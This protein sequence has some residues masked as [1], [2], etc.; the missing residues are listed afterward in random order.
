MQAQHQL[1]SSRIAAANHYDEVAEAIGTA[2]ASWPPPATVV[3]TLLEPDGAHRFVGAYGMSAYDRSEWARV[4]PQFDVPIVTVARDRTVLV[5]TDRAELRARFPTMVTDRYGAEAVF[6]APLLD[7]DRVIGSLGLTWKESLTVDDDIRRYLGALA[8]PAARKVAE[9]TGDEAAAGAAWVL[10]TGLETEGWLPIVLETIADPAMVLAPV[11][12][13]DRV[14]DFAVEYANTAA[15]ELLKVTRVGSDQTLLETYPRIGAELLLPGFT[16]LL[17][18]GGP[19]NVGPARLNAAADPADPDAAQVMTV[20]ASRVWDRV[21]MTWRIHSEAE[22]IY[23]QL[24]EAERIGRIGSFSWE[25]GS[26]EPRCSPQLYRL[27]Y[28]DDEAHPIPVDELATCVHEDDLPAVQDA[29]RRTLVGGEQLTWEFRGARRLAGRRLRIAA[30][31]VLGA[32]G[33]VTTI[34]GTV[35]DVTEERAIESR[36]RLAEEA[37][38]AQRRRLDAELRAA[39]ALQRA[40]LPTEPELG[41]TDGL[42]VSGRCRVSDNS[43]RVDGD[44]YDAC[45]LP[46]K[47]TLLVVGDVAGSGLAAMTAAARLRYAVRAYAALDM[48]PGEILGAVNTMLCS[49]EP[50][51]TA[52]LAV[53]RYGSRDRRLEWAVAGQAAPVR[54]RRNGHAELLTG[55]LGLPVGAAPQVTYS[56]AS[57]DLAHGDRV[58]LYT[59][60]L[61][62]GRGRDVVEALD[63]LLG[64]GAHANRN[65]V[66]ALVGYVLGALH[67]GPDEDMGAMLVRVD[68]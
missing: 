62:G 39:Q 4:P 24:L 23:P 47:A 30:E 3:I 45:A 63:V 55:P 27:Y 29:I 31:P 66:E 5:I 34:R 21:L 6:A 2:V 14:I 60:G 19:L 25:V 12:S 46:G 40:L 65:D 37:L 56:E 11:R 35:Q 59:D 7:G 28:G 1:I 51:R 9:L 8:A 16:G 44:W 64:A 22:L 48:S 53:A 68:S 13:D 10:D 38:A 32:D 26:P 20:R 41:T 43:G 18:S 54:Y 15:T 57:V 50:E 61:I 36:L 67:S 17:T 33:T 52:T 49:L 58:L 42:W